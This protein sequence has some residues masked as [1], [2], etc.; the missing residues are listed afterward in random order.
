MSGNSGDLP[1]VVITDSNFGDDA[2]EREV[3]DGRALLRTAAV[4]QPSEV[5]AV[6]SG[7][8]ALLVQFAQIDAE[9]FKALGSLRVIVRYGIGLDTIDLDAAAT[10]GVEVCNVDDYCI[11]EVADHTA[12][13]VAAA[14]RRLTVF[15]REAKSNGWGP[16]L[17]PT[18]LPPS[19]DPVGVAGFGRIGEAVSSRLM[20]AGHPVFVWDPPAEAKAAAAGIETAPS[21]AELAERVNHLCL[22]VPAMEATIGMVDAEVLERLGRDGH[23]V[24]TARGALVDEL[25]LLAWLDASPQAFASLDVLVNEPPGGSSATLAAHSRTLVTPH[26]AYLSSVSLPRLR[27]TAAAQVLEGLS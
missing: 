15:D 20:A 13:V 16:Y 26:V 22:H 14:S 5:I 3:L 8:T 9:V 10:H 24:N 18:P 2:I 1:L 21:L 19:G 27:R 23:L 7:A 11:D 12:A 25:A 4:T 6:S 17:A